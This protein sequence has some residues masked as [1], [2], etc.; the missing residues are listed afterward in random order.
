MNFIEIITKLFGNKSQK[1]M[2][3]IKPYVDKINSIYPTLSKLSNDDLRA[4]T[5]VIKERI[6]AHVQPQKD[7]IAQLKSSIEQLPIEKRES[8]YRK[9]D[10]LDKDIKKGYEQILNEVLPEVFAIVKDTARRFTENETVVVTAND[11]DRDLAARFDFVEIDGDKAVYHNHW[12]AGGNEITWN[13]IHYDVQLIGGV[14]LHQGKIAEMATGEGK[15]LVATLPVFLNALT[16]EGV[17]VITVNDYLAKRDAEWN[18]PIYMFH[19]LSVDCIDK[20]RPN[21]E[22]RRQAYKCDITFGTNNEFGF[23]YLRDNMATSP[24]DLVQ[25]KHNYA[26]VDEVDSALIDDAR[27][28]LIIS[29]P[30]PKGE[31][32]MFDEYKHRVELLVRT[33]QTLTNKY[34]AEAKAKLDSPDKAVQEEGELALFRS[35]KGMPKAKALIKYLSEP[36]VKVRLQKTE[37]FYMQEQNKNMHIAT[38]P[39][40]FVIDEKNKHIELTDL[41]AETLAGQTEDPN[42]FV[43][44]DVGSEIAD[45]EK[46]QLSKEEMTTRKDA[47]MTNYAVKSERVHTVNQLLKAYT[48]FEKD[49]DYV[50]MNN[51][52]KIVDEQTGRIME[53]RRW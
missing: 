9:I 11:F 16:H 31:D 37:E 15:T 5:E 32:Q 48:L 33:Q 42:F 3:A 43:L 49:V 45:L 22:E 20:Y 13:M 51:E 2:K 8:V 17:H 4:R 10:D 34:L 39:L 7:E 29:G 46:E 12:M 41:G 52:V 19:G 21:S 50:V 47:I 53:G 18:G 25:R 24:K 14:V 1:D 44:P 23:D 30:V 26:I 38:D 27:T 6:A 40:Y 36:G 28:P 35:Y